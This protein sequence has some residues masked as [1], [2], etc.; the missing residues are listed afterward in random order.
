MSA[1][2]SSSGGSD[3][4]KRLLDEAAEDYGTPEQR[5]QRAADARLQSGFARSSGG[6]VTRRSGR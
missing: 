1:N 4:T 2:G 6:Q 3:R 5:E